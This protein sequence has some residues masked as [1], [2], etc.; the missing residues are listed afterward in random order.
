MQDPRDWG[1]PR[2]FVL[3]LVL[4]KSNFR[5]CTVPVSYQMVGTVEKICLFFNMVRDFWAKK[6]GTWIENPTWAVKC[7]WIAWRPQ[8][9]LG[10]YLSMCLHPQSRESPWLCTPVCPIYFWKHLHVFIFQ[11]VKIPGSFPFFNQREYIYIEEIG[12]FPHSLGIG[13]SICI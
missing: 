9:G 4:F 2:H 13:R 3:F 6:S 8:E 1:Q 7:D 5:I 10:D 12:F 11:M